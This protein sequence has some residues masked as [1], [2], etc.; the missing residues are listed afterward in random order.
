MHKTACRYCGTMIPTNELGGWDEYH[1]CK[2]GKDIPIGGDMGGH[3]TE[4]V[5][6]DLTTR[7]QEGIRQTWK[8]AP[9]SRDLVEKNLRARIERLE[10]KLDR[11]EQFAKDM[12]EDDCHYGD[13]CPPFGTRHGTCSGCQAREALKEII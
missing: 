9:E 11:L 2:E 10:K 1:D 3:H 13:N 8:L 4:Q 5:M 7:L 12:A 6:K